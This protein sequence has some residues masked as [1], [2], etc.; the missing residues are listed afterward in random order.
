MRILGL[1][2]FFAPLAFAGLMLAWLWNWKSLI[3]CL[4]LLTACA[5]ASNPP[6]LE[7]PAHEEEEFLPAPTWREH[8]YETR[9]QYITSD[10]LPVESPGKVSELMPSPAS[11]IPFNVTTQGGEA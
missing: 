3:P 5:T 7:V 9:A 10:A 2:I 4:L 11:S 8:F 6:T 1:L